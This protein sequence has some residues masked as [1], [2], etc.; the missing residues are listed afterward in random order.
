ME[1]PCAIVQRYHRQVDLRVP[2]LQES[3]DDHLFAARVDAAVQLDPRPVQKEAA[4]V[5]IQRRPHVQI[6]LR[7]GPP[8]CQQDLQHPV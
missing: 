1:C 7:Q 5:K 8:S 2:Y 6:K 4:E 3:A